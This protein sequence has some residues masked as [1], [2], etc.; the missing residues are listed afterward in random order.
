MCACVAILVNGCGPDKNK[1]LSEYFDGVVI[2]KWEAQP[3]F[4]MIIIS[5]GRIID[6][7]KDVC[8]CSQAKGAVWG[9]LSVGDSLF[10]N[11]GSLT[12]HVVRKRIDKAFDYPNCYK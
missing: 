7:L 1:R 4:G 6:T 10:K 3:C 12:W 11:E 5:Q 8:I 9:Y 2:K